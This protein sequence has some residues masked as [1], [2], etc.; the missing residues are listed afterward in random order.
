MA[1][2]E[3][4]HLEW[5]GKE[6]VVPSNQVMRL[7]ARIED[8]IT[9]AELGNYSARGGL[10]IAKLCSAY[11]V[12]LRHAGAKVND[13]E[14][15]DQAL[16]H[17]EQGFIVAAVS[18]VM[19]MM[20]PPKARS[21]FMESREADASETAEAAPPEKQAAPLADLSGGPTKLRSGRGG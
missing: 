4:I 15:Y 14:I 9:L 20:L 2:F 12:A 19:L 10:P 21:K 16:S 6:Y 11:G 13:E 18:N 5:E 3:D 1:I 17:D 8:I 7:I